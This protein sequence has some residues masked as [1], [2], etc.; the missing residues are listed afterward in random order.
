MYIRTDTILDK[1]LEQK[2]REIDLLRPE[3][4]RLKRAAEDA[5]PPRDF[6]AALHRET[7]ALI[8]EVKQASPS[9]GV[10]IDPFDPIHLSRIYTDNGAAAISVLT[11]AEFFRG[12]LEHMRQVRSGVSLPVLRKDFII[13]PLQIHEG[14]AAGADAMLLIVAVLEDAVLRDLHALITGLGMT[15]LVEVHDERE[16]ER[17]LAAGAAVIGVNNRDLR[18]FHEDLNTT[19]RLAQWIP[20]SV[21]LVAESAIRS[22]AD[23]R[24]MAE[25]G[26]NAVLIGEGLVRAGDIGEQV[27]LFSSQPTTRKVT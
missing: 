9:K 2:V 17:A 25:A 21:T 16:L 6:A 15:A 26:A 3:A 10:L 18:T 27:R 23:V 12:S 11:D 8:A 19:V 7:V 24:R 14:R 4:A 5:P 13:D 1:I 20:S 22:V